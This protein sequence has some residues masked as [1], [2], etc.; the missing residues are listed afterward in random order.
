MKQSSYFTELHQNAGSGF[1]LE[2]D[3]KITEVVTPY[4]T[5]SIYKTKTFGNLMIIDDCIML[6]TRDN[7]LY[8]EMMSHPV[9]NTHPDPKNV[10]IIGGGDCGTLQEVLKHKSVEQ[11]WQVD[12]DEMVTR[13]SEEYFPELCRANQD[14]RANL[15]FE[16]GIKWMKDRDDR[17]VD[18]IIVDSTDPI[19][20]AEGLFQLPFYQNCQRVL[21]DNGLLIQQSE[22]PL[23]HFESIIKPMHSTLKQAGFN[24]TQT[25][26][27]PQPVYPSGWWSATMASKATQFMQ[28]RQPGIEQLR[29]YNSG[30]HG[31]ALQLPNFMR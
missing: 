6:T 23:L 4:Q 18:I 10:V 22:S 12:I 2:I 1:L 13:L 20:P 15:L 7:F 30:V 31:A 11:V 5:I 29:Y 8:H 17:S 16:D 19:G 25:L 9:L 27:F 21:R 28:F 3:K 26:L 14:S 24:A